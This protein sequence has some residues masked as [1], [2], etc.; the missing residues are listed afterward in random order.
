MVLA[1]VRNR[2]ERGVRRLI[3]HITWTLRR[4]SASSRRLARPDAGTHKYTASKDPR[5]VRRPS[6]SSPQPWKNQSRQVQ[7]LHKRI[8][9][10]NRIINRHTS[11]KSPEKVSIGIAIVRDVRIMTSNQ[12]PLQPL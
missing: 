4:V 12:I 2:L 7:R 8:D 1:E 10:P 3:S 11:S 6:I 9:H 5:R